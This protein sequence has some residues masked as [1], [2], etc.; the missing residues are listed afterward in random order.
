MIGTS[1]VK[2]TVPNKLT[3]RSINNIPLLEDSGKNNVSKNVNLIIVIRRFVVSTAE[4]HSPLFGF[5][6]L[7]EKRGTIIQVTVF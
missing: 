4:Y 1:L 7:C 3:Y 5:M 2:A 6:L